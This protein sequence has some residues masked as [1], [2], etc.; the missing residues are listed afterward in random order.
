MLK[1]IR[2]RLL[3]ALIGCGVVMIGLRGADIVSRLID[4]SAVQPLRAAQAAEPPKAD[5]PIPAPAVTASA[6]AP[7]D[8]HAPTDPDFSPAEMD[9][10]Q[11]LAKRRAEIEQRDTAVQQREA[12]LKVAED[13]VNQ[14]LAEL[15][16]LKAD[17]EKLLDLQKKK[18]DDQVMSLVKIYSGMKPQDAARI[19]NTLEMPV[20]LS[21]VSHMKEQK[22]AAI[23]AGM[24]PD[25][26]RELTTRLADLRE[27]P[28]GASADAGTAGT[29]T[30]LIP[31]TAT[32]ALPAA[33]AAA[34]PLSPPAPQAARAAAPEPPA[35]GK[36][37]S[38]APHNSTPSKPGGKAPAQP[39]G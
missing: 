2:L 21:V 26:A 36:T 11:N 38:P 1:G 8:R 27:L 37:A 13:R 3:P 10:L 22:S 23:I 18:Q 5:T 6:A 31:P 32:A 16:S 29:P 7:A 15:S 24:Q 14:K 17:I 12:M 33:P 25:R 20:L 39:A 28:D 19:F 35:A 34:Q 4:G 30:A 9:L